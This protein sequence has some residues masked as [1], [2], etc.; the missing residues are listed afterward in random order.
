MVR[1]RPI[2]IVK[3]FR[4]ECGGQRDEQTD[5]YTIYR[6]CCAVIVDPSTSYRWRTS[7]PLFSAEVAWVSDH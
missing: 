5:G 4:H 1:L 3:S 6:A 7:N 2:K